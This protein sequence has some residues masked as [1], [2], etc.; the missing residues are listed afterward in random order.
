MGRLW[1]LLLAALTLVTLVA[2][3]VANDFV[4]V[5]PTAVLWVCYLL[6]YRARERARNSA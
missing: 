4:L 6:T 1:F 5:I 3:S 2:V